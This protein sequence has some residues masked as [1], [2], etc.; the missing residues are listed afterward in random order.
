MKVISESD[1]RIKS[2]VLILLF[3]RMQFSFVD[4]WNV[5]EQGVCGDCNQTCSL[6]LIYIPSVACCNA[7]T[8]TNEIV[9]AL[10]LF[11]FLL[12]ECF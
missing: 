5:E 8:K 1:R 2:A 7:D 12:Q 10:I 11:Y 3:L 6:S 9:E 4:E